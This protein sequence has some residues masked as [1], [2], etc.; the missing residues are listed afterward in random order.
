VNGY[1]LD[2]N[3]VSELRKGNR[4]D[5]NAITWFRLIDADE[6]FLSVLVP[7]EI[8]KGVEL[9]RKHDPAK[10]EALEEWLEQ[11][12]VIYAERLLPITAGI[13]DRWGRLSA[14]RPISTVDGLMAATALEG[15]LTLVT[16]NIEDVRHTGVKL[17]NPFAA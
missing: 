9:A 8:R 4:A 5:P 13:S 16:R 1:L 11:L 6:L 17:L 15:S 3:F 2:T 10:A 7:G 14:I 12:S